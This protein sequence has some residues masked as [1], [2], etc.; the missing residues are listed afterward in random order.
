L[1]AKEAVEV[2]DGLTMSISL[3]WFIWKARNDRVFLGT[4]PMDPGL[5]I[6]KAVDRANEFIQSQSVEVQNR[7][8]REIRAARWSKP[9]TG[10][11]K[12][13]VDA[14]WLPSSWEA[15]MGAVVRDW[16]GRQLCAWNGGLGRAKSAHLAPLLAL[17]LALLLVVQEVWE[18]VW[19]E[20]DAAVVVLEVIIGGWSKEGEAIHVDIKRYLE[21]IQKS[22]IV[23][24]LREVP[25][26]QLTRLRARRSIARLI[27]NPRERTPLANVGS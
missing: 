24:Q 14:S 26:L 4:C 5:V 18:R 1:K 6:V 11:V 23:G 19:L 7:R 9:A 21:A 22:P 16:E 2:S 12:L 17:R 3:M 27:T 15:S 13:N 8:L 25:I 20:V 10:V